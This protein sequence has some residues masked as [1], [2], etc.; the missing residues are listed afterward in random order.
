MA[1][2]TTDQWLK[3]LA[4]VSSKRNDEGYTARELMALM[5]TNKKRVMSKLQEL[6]AE[7]RLIAGRKTLQNISGGLST[8]PCYRFVTKK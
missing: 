4:K 2:I 5:G 8:V 1:T 3:E 6:N 7:G